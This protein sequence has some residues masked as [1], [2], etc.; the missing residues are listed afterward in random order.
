MKTVPPS[1]G[2][3]FL[4]AMQSL[5]PPEKDLEEVAET[6]PYALA[7]AVFDITRF[8]YPENAETADCSRKMAIGNLRIYRRNPYP[9]FIHP[10]QSFLLEYQTTTYPGVIFRLISRIIQENK[11]PMAV[12]NRINELIEVL[13][14]A[15]PHKS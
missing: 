12:A 13:E 1:K 15:S 8:L 5:I 7:N 2:V 6:L 10:N 14:N 3:G 9:F 4:G 11:N